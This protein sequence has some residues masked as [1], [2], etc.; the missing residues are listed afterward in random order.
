MP[1]PTQLLEAV[2]QQASRPAPAAVQALGEALRERYGAAVQAILFYGSCLR[3]GD[4]RE[5][6]VDL[7]MLVDHYSSVYPK[8]LLALL[9]RLLPPNVFYLEIPFSDRIARA[10]YAIISLAD[11]EH[12]TSMHWFQSYLWG[13]FAQPVG[14][15]YTRNERISAQIHYA[16]ATAVT[17]FIT[18][19]LPQLSPRFTAQELWLQ[20][21]ALSYATELRVERSR[22]RASQLYEAIP[23]YYDLITRASLPTLPFRVQSETDTNRPYYQSQ[24]DTWTRSFSR[25]SWALRRFQGKLLTILRLIK[26]VFTFAGGVDYILWKIQRHSGTT[27]EVTP[28]MRRHPVLAGGPILW[29]LYRGGKLR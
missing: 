6:I 13:R 12:G 11:F 10:K 21:L 14:L 8:P 20:G 1:Q 15:V 4:D 22:G 19:V 25:L 17:T 23:A 18:R 26:A 24:I 5:G 3:S 29:R 27:I 28:W 7:Y 2:S 16:L 9:N